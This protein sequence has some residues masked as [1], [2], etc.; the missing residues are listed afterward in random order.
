[1]ARSSAKS[2]SNQAQL[3]VGG[4]VA[5]DPNSSEM[6]RNGRRNNNDDPAHILDPDLPGGNK[7]YVRPISATVDESGRVRLS[8]AR[9]D[10]ESVAVKEGNVDHIHAGRNLGSSR[11]SA[12]R[13][14]LSFNRPPQSANYGIAL[15]DQMRMANQQDRTLW[16][17]QQQDR[18]ARVSGFDAE[19]AKLGAARNVK[20]GEGQGTVEMIEQLSRGVG[21]GQQ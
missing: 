12:V 7:V 6:G 2:T 18:R 4:F 13:L 21:S 1:M 15:P 10:S 3:G 14:P 11:P 5:L 9:A 17:Q 8:V 16:Q 20:A 19:A